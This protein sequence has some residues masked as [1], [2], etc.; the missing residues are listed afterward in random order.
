MAQNHSNRGPSTKVSRL[1]VEA[2]LSAGAVLAVLQLCVQ[3]AAWGVSALGRWRVA[4]LTSL[5]M[6]TMVVAQTASGGAATRAASSPEIV[7][8]ADEYARR[9]LARDASGLAALFAPD[10]YELPPNQPAVK[11]RAAIEAWH[12]SF[13]NGPVTM[14]AFTL[15]HIQTMKKAVE[16]QPPRTT[17]KPRR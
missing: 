13:F 8:I 15:S 4:V 7:R 10:A 3:G 1:L 9:F 2:V 5:F 11:G 17:S 16:T 12:Q 6:S 14:T